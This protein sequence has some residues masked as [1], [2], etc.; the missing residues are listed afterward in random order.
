MPSQRPYD[1]ARSH[2]DEIAAGR[3]HWAPLAIP[4]PRRLQTAA[5]L[6]HTL[7]MSLCFSLFWF[8]LA[9]PLS[10][11]LL[12]PYLVYV[13]FID[14]KHVDGSAPY[15]RSEF[16]RRLPVWRLY[17]DYFPMRLHR[18]APLDPARNYIFAYHPHGIISHGA[19]GNFVTEAT[20]FKQLFP[21]I[22]NTLLTID[23]N[24]K[25]PFN[26]EYL[27]ALGLASV[28]RHSCEAI[29][30]GEG[31]PPPRPALSLWRPSTW[32]AA[33]PG[34][35]LPAEARGGGGGGRAITIVV[36]GAQES[37]EA[38]PGSMKLVCK[39]RRG[40]L[41]LA[42][43]EGAGVVPVLSFGENGGCRFPCNS[44]GRH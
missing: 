38:Q 27:L 32:S 12:L 17:A 9:I 29:L 26:R 37:L 13:F 31:M 1:S 33:L 7:S 21:G 11:P 16:L 18:T 15:R 39:K 5:V 43:R 28:S 36:G 34:S 23:Y 42:M 30:R 10:W 4:L 44:A 25:I 41:K 6:F 19:F 2:A 3:V 14:T 20:G 24:F 35:R 22:R 40:F 8:V